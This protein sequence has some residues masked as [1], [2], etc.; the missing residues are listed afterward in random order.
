MIYIKV[1]V[2][3]PFH[4]YNMF[5]DCIWIPN[6]VNI[7]TKILKNVVEIRGMDEYTMKYTFQINENVCLDREFKPE[8]PA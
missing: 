6:I 1:Y 5:I 3:T 7:C 4:K 8:T 2:N